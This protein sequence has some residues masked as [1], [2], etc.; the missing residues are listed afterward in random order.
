MTAVENGPV[1]V[2]LVGAGEF[3]ASL[4][5]QSLG[6]PSISVVAVAEKNTDRALNVLLRCGVIG[7]DMEV[8][9]DAGAACH[10]MARKA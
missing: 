9:R 2:G 4:I 7:A 5:T 8:C 6:H 3:G 1:R 10:A